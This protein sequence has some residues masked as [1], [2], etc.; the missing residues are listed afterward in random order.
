MERRKALAVATAATLVLGGAIVGTA[1]VSGASFLGFGGTKHGPG[2][3]AASV[4]S[5]KQGVVVKNH[6]VYDRYV[7]DTGG[8]PTTTAATGGSSSAGAARA[9]G[10]WPA[11]TP[12]TAPA[13]NPPNATPTTAHHDDGEH[14]PGATTPTSTPH[15]AELPEPEPTTTAPTPT[16]AP[17]TTPTTAPREYHVPPNWPK[18]AAL[19]PFPSGPCSEPTLYWDGVD[20]GTAYWVCDN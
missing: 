15:D 6:D 1:S 8:T 18:G 19:P 17:A 13:P 2:S 14:S 10:T 9:E 7:V 11:S 4:V 12:T 5:T 16:T 3:F 20:T